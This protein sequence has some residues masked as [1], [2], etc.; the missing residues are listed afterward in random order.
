MKKIILPFLFLFSVFCA[1]A[2][3]KVEDILTSGKWFIESVQ[4]QG[5]HPEKVEDKTEE[6]LVFYADGK[7]KQCQFEEVSKAD[8]QYLQK[9]KA[10]KISNDEVVLQ[11][12]IEISAEKLVL[13]VANGLDAKEHLIV[14]YVK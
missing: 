12:I 13:E 3:E 9:E 4:E 1:S 14:T 6:W 11:K 8:W 5:K 7:V 2:Q 10:I